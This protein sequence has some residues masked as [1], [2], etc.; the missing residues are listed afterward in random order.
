MSKA[1]E[2]REIIVRVFKATVRK[3]KEEAFET[4]FLETALPLVRGQEG[5]VS[6]TVGLAHESSPSDFLMVTVWRDL[7][8]L[9]AF[10]GEQW[11]MAV[12]HP[13]EEHLLEEIAVSHYYAT[14]G[15]S[16]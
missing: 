9:K 6:V 14:Q 5:L 16:G 2:A 7:N 8:A 12:V 13:D 15:G 1:S 3:G 4:F 11:E 10:A